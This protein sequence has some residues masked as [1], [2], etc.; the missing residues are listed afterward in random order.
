MKEPKSEA[1]NQD[2]FPALAS[3]HGSAAFLRIIQLCEDYQNADIEGHDDDRVRADADRR[4]AQILGVAAQAYQ[5]SPERLRLALGTGE[6]PLAYEPPKSCTNARGFV[7][8]FLE[9]L[10][11]NQ[12]KCRKCGTVI[13]IEP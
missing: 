5:M 6:R 3:A 11:G 8:H 12:W 2:G 7:A 13:E 9:L 1:A 4:I 10:E